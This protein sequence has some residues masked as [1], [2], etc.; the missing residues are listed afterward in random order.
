MQVLIKKIIGNAVA[1]DVSNADR[2]EDVKAQ[3]QIKEGI[4][5]TQQDLIFAGRR[6][7]N[8]SMIQDYKINKNDTLN[9]IIRMR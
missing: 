2:V 3:I 9:L 7:I 5:L 1:Y 4:P 8:G 6:L